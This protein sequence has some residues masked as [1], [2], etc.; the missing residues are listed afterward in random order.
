MRLGYDEGYWCHG[1]MFN[2]IK[3]CL[4]LASG[5][6]SYLYH[7]NENILAAWLTVSIISTLYSYVWDLKMDFHLLQ[8][9]NRNF[10]LRKYLTFTPKNIYYV[11]MVT[12]LIFRLVW[13]LTLSPAIIDVFGDSALFSFLSGSIEISRR[14]I[15]NLLR[16]EREHL[17]N[18]N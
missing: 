10:L 8:S 9:N 14:G 1:N 16:V 3:Y 18:C 11:I 5:I 4:S 2:T 17:A 6:L 7:Q 15:W 12:N 13:T